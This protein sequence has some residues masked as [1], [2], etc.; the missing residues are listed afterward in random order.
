MLTATISDS[1]WIINH[2]V[3]YIYLIYLC[4]E[5]S[6]DNAKNLYTIAQRKSWKKYFTSSVGLYGFSNIEIDK[7]GT[8]W[9][10][11]ECARTM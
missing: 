2:V 6:I 1:N 11:G 8:V 4:G 10:F 3:K 7:S 9:A 5:S